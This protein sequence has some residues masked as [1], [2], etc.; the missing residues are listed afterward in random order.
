MLNRFKKAF[1]KYLQIGTSE[2]KSHDAN[3]LFF[4]SNLF[5]LIG[6]SIT[7]MMAIN[8]AVN[9]NKVL[10][11]SLFSASAIFFFCHHVHRFTS[12]DNT[13]EI[14]TRIIFICLM[15][16][17]LYLVY[18]GGASNTGPLWIYIVPPVAFFFSGLKRG[19]KYISVFVII[20]SLM[21]FYPNDALLD[22]HYL[23]EFKT[24][25]LLSFLTVTLLFGFYEYSR[26]SSYNYS[27]ELS[28]T[29]EKQ[30]MQDTLTKLPNRRAMWSHLHH[31][32]NR[33]VRSNAPFSILICDI[34]HFKKINDQYMHDG[35]DFVLE[36][37]SQFFT[38]NIRQQDI[39]ARW[40]GEEFIFL[41]PETKADDA[42]ILAEKLR[43]NIEDHTIQYNQ[44]A[45][46]LT[47]SIGLNEVSSNLSIERAINLADH[48][49]Y[50][51]KKNGRNQTKRRLI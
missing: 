11:I 25:L 9:G 33:S 45:I 39:V 51:A 28:Q 19:L 21:L 27:Q 16:L 7:L 49:L 38:R 24:R 6:Y 8:A 13:I 17:M 29:Y 10:A 1:A 30:A 23:F 42:F 44:S 46:K 35:G 43:K 48:Y 32:Y 22:T 40:G 50:E 41:L 15:T 2:D 36:A 20:I 31:E 5:S 26:Q 14:S 18:S 3:Q 37:L 47:L 12:L 34:D 4:V